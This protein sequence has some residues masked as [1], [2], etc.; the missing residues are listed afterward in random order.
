MERVSCCGYFGISGRIDP[1]VTD[2]WPIDRPEF[3][4]IGDVFEWMSNGTLPMTGFP[5]K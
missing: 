1:A 3:F 4:W 5:T 2:P